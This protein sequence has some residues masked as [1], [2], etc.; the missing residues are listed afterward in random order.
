MCGWL[1]R[2]PAVEEFSAELLLTCCWLSNCVRFEIWDLLIERNKIFSK[3]LFN[4]LRRHP[5]VAN[6]VFFLVRLFG[7]TIQVS[8]VYGHFRMDGLF[9]Y[10]TASESS[11]AMRK[12][13]AGS[14]NLGLVW[15]WLCKIGI[16]WLNEK[17]KFQ[18]ERMYV[19]RNCENGENTESKF[20]LREQLNYCSASRSNPE[21]VCL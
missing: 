10:F 6:V 20:L 14:E 17:C 5:V 21:C 4:Q 18:R 3:T 8:N 19:S 7:C 13:H 2:E 11:G 16:L 9:E 12:P 15:V 1:V